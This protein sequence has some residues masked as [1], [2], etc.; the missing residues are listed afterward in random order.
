MVE[1]VEAVSVVEVVRVEG[2]WG[3]RGSRDIKSSWDRMSSRKSKVR[4]GSGGNR[5]R[6]SIKS[7]WCSRN[8]TGSALHHPYIHFKFT[9]VWVV[10]TEGNP[11]FF[12]GH[13]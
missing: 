11:N 1:V 5:N 12:P 10:P 3:S 6:W 4:M 13:T 2:S 9:R 8:S 7:R